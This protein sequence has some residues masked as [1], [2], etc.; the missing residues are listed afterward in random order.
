MRAGQLLL[1]TG[2]VIYIGEGRSKLFTRCDKVVPG[3]G[4]TNL[5]L[6]LLLL[7]PVSESF[8]TRFDEIFD[9]FLT[10]F[11]NFLITF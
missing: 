4:A 3:I 7:L 2:Q 1:G 11:D 8:I 5:L 10:T 9:N 6:L